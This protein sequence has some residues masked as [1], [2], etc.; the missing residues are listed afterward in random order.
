MADGYTTEQIYTAIR[1]AGKAGDGN[2][3]RALSAHLQAMQAQQAPAR[4]T[5]ADRMAPP[6]APLSKAQRF[7]AG[8]AD[9]LIGAEQL[10]DNLLPKTSVQHRPGETAQ[11][12]DA[13]NKLS[14]DSARRDARTVSNAGREDRLKARSP[15]G[16]DWMRLA[17]NILS[18]A[19]YIGGVGA[20]GKAMTLE[21]AALSGAGAAAFQPVAGQADFAVNK[22]KQ[23]AEG[24]L[25]GAAFQPI[26]GH[27]DVAANKLKQMAEETGRL[28]GTLAPRLKPAAQQVLNFARGVHGKEL[29]E[30]TA[31]KRVVSRLQA[32]AEG[33]APTAQDLIDVRATRAGK[34]LTLMDVGG[35]EIEALAG[36]MS[37]AQGGRQII[38]EFLNKRDFGAG[39][40]IAADI[41]KHV[42]KG[43]SAYESVEALLK[44]RK[45]AAAPLYKKAYEH[46]PI[47]SR[48]LGTERRYR[49]SDGP[50]RD[51]KGYGRRI[52][53]RGGGGRRSQ[54]PRAHV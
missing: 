13:V 35:H 20:A 39:S 54:Q 30:A 42:S 9:P 41:R 17:G 47:K 5:I 16:T 34:P 46:P 11:Q 52:A 37:R 40:R 7:G 29:P 15:E 8:L 51:E 50:P 10:F 6:P 49:G 2:A 53:H 45:D 1:A 31:V 27:V 3:V 43:G 44:A 14:A 18:P 32:G 12:R 38:S 21:R 28:V 26:A 33:G 22:L 23:M 4:K 19:N 36:R 25:G 24:A 48:R